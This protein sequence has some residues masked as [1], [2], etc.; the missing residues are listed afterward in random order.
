MNNPDLILFAISLLVPINIVCSLWIYREMLNLSGVL[1]GELNSE[2]TGNYSPGPRKPNGVFYS[3]PNRKYNEHSITVAYLLDHSSNPELT[4]KLAKWQKISFIPSFLSFI[5]TIYITISDNEKEYLYATIGIAILLVMNFITLLLRRFY[6]EKYPLDEKV[7]AQLEKKKREQ[8]KY[9]KANITFFFVYI[10]AGVLVT[11]MLFIGNSIVFGLG[12]P[13]KSDTTNNANVQ[14]VVPTRE[15][16]NKT[17]KEYGFETYEKAAQYWYVIDTGL[18]IV[19]GEKGSTKFEFYEISKYQYND[20]DCEEFYYKMI[21][22][23]CEDNS[24]DEKNIF[25]FSLNNGGKGIW[26]IE[27]DVERKLFLKGHT[28]VYV[29]WDVNVDTQREIDKIMKTLHYK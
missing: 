5:I 28:I 20:N 10:I 6:R 12:E 17:V 7:S 4:L 22:E 21:D 14:V 16:V 15:Y 27:K 1:H 29:Y 3:S 8:S 23:I 24:I 11:F 13:T 18:D 9:S 25:P 19:A 26:I 2:I